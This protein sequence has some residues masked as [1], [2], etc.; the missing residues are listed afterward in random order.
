MNP[1]R[2][3]VATVNDTLA[4]LALIQDPEAV[5]VSLDALKV[6][7]DKLWGILGDIEKA[8]RKLQE[9]SASLDGREKDVQE[10]EVAASKLFAEASELKAD[11][12]AKR[13]ALKSILS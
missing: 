2:P 4:L 3:A 8:G 10:K 1:A 11:Y 13:A 5:K 9:D 7:L 12:E 6:D